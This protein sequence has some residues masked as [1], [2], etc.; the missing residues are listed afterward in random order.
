MRGVVIRKCELKQRDARLP[1][2]GNR[3]GDPQTIEYEASVNQ[4]S[5]S[6]QS[7]PSL[8][9]TVHSHYPT[10]TSAAHDDPERH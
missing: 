5:I 6:V 4:V 1:E 2:K 8:K 10:E 3:K 7:E 9:G